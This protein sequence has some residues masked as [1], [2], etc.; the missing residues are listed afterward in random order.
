MSLKNYEMTKYPK[1]FSKCYWGNFRYNE[2]FEESVKNR[3]EFIEIYNP[4]IKRNPPKYIRENYED[5]NGNRKT[6]TDHIEIYEIKNKYIIFSSPYNSIENYSQYSD[7]GWEL[8]KEIYG[9]GTETFIKF[10]D[11]RKN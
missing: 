9:L 5:L 10:I 2:N 1:I 6:H 8:Y 3:N 4:K 7:D 11:K